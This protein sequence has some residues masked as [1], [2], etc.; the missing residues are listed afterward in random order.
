MKVL[1]TYYSH[2][3]NTKKLAEFIAKIIKDEF[4]NA[5]I[6]F[7][8]AEPEKAYSK[9]YNAV[10]DEAK[11]DIKNNHKPKLKNSIEGIE[12]YDVIF[13]GSPN[14]WNT[15]APPVNSFINSF[16]LSNK[17]IMPFCTHGGGGA[18]NIK[19]DIEKESKSKQTAKILSVY[20]SSA[21]RSENEIRKWIKDI[22]IKTK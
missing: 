1:I 15:M 2:S 12:S 8:N 17:I 5:K 10:L 21:S 18:G 11:R 4:Q 22:F 13:I 3:S 7:F 16:D 19:R 6:D 20:G 9:N 14:W